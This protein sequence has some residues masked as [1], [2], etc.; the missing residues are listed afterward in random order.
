MEGKKASAVKGMI[1]KMLIVILGNFVYAC[2]IVFFVIPSGLIT[3]GTTG[4]ALALNHALGIPVSPVVGAVNAVM[5]LLGFFV[6][7]KTFAL[8]TLVS[9][10]AYPL[11]LGAL[12]EVVGDFVLTTDLFIS[13]LFGGL[14]IGG[15]MAVIIRLGAS[16]GGMDIPPLILNK[17]FRIPVGGSLYVFDFMILI[18]QA[19]FSNRMS[20]LYGVFLVLVYTFT[21]DKLSAYGTRRMQL[22]IVSERH[23]EIR[24][25]ILE[26]I[27]RGVTL[28]HAKTGFL[29]RETEMIKCAIAPR[30]LHKVETMIHQIDP[31]AFIMLNQISEVSGRGFSREKR[32]LKTAET[33][34][35]GGNEEKEK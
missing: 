5:F 26:D 24:Q 3:G 12:Q 25:A 4:I 10:I 32:Y 33:A 14:C 16:T 8:T 35:A 19:F 9:T 22:E 15:S 30:E 18:A 21:I 20:I 28:L 13:A 27:D 11:L 29:G 7:G 17:L 31:D 1:R 34:P 6:L 23:E 2:G